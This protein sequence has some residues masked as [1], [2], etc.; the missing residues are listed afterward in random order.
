M[1]KSWQRLLALL[2]V[3][4]FALSCSRGGGPGAE[5]GK[6]GGALVVRTAPVATRDVVYRVQAL[7]SLEPDELVQVT[8]E[9]SGAVKEVLFQAGDR[10]TAETVIARIDPDRYRLEAE[11]ADAAWRR[12]VADWKRAEADLSRR[13]ALAKENL[14]AVEELA[15]ARRETERLAADTSA[16]QAALGIARQNQERASVRTPRGGEINTRTVETGQFVQAGT[17]LA[18]VVDIRKLRLRFKVSESE[19]L[20]VEEGRNVAFRVAALGAKEFSARVYH[21]GAVA[22]AGTRRVEVLA[23]VS[24]PGPLKPGFFAEVTLATGTH[25]NAVAVPE[26]AVL[27]S[28]R[29][30][31]VYVVEG[32]KAVERPVG[33]GLRTGDGSV[34]ILSGLKGGETIVTEGSDRLSDG[35]PVQPA[36]QAVASPARPSRGDEG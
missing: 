34:E 1:V 5:K 36:P 32:G 8:A 33:I 15:R 3:S 17:V 16:A 24:N 2:V 20:K 18:T 22:D 35:V 12:A 11:R 27:A 7:G 19:S 21:V 13:E 6:R 29:G 25:P 4:G 14:V 30:F 28:E 23:W 9:V 31:V 26:G 10:V